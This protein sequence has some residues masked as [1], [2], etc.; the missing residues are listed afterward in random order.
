MVR[1]RSRPYGLCH[2]PYTKAHIKGFGSSYLHVYACLLLC[3]MLVLASL[4]LGF[5]MLDALHGLDLVWLH[6]MPMRPCL[7]VTI[8]EASPDAGFL[9]TYTSL[10]ALYDAMLTMFVRSTRWLSMHPYTLAHMSMHESCLLVYH[11]YFHTMKLWTFNPNLHLSLVDTTFCF[12]SWL[13]AFSHVCLLSCFFDCHVY[14]AYLFYPSFI[15]SL[16]LILPLLIC[17]FLVI[18]F[19]CTHMEWGR[20]ELW[21]S[22]LGESKKGENAGMWILLENLVFYLIQNT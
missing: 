11:P 5:A 10:F 14:H 3:F 22:L 13:F 16:H 17:S 12:L 15:C 21:H 7:D 18:A 8:W 9:H 2:R 4:V 19:A 6:P 20:M 1:T